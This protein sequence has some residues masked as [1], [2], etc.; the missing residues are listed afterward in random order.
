MWYRGT[1]PK[2][3][4]S[5][6]DANTDDELL[7]RWRRLLNKLINQLLQLINL[8]GEKTNQLRVVLNTVH[9]LVRLWVPA[10][11]IISPLLFKLRASFS[12]IVRMIYIPTSGQFCFWNFF[13]SGFPSCGE[14]RERG[15][16]R[17]GE[18]NG[19]EQ[20]ELVRRGP[21]YPPGLRGQELVEGSSAPRLGRYRR[22]VRDDR[23]HFSPSPLDL[24]LTNANKSFSF[25]FSV[26]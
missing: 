13:K 8:V 6:G 2:L 23:E 10:L 7:L 21:P 3:G 16:A 14:K 5:Q 18:K 9:E 19:G 15:G 12:C 25:Y 24:S 20:G 17:E 26:Y 11:R 22:E 1:P 4:T